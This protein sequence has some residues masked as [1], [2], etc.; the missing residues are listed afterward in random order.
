MNFLYDCCRYFD[1]L[2]SEQ[3]YSSSFNLFLESLIKLESH[4]FSVGLII[5]SFIKRPGIPSYPN[6]PLSDK[7]TIIIFKL[8]FI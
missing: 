4:F 5:C 7:N 3:I 2:Y 8:G 1:S 6:L